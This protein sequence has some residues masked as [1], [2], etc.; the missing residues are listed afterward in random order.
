MLK[1]HADKVILR[2]HNQVNSYYINLNDVREYIKIL[3]DFLQTF[4]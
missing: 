4:K 2:Y 3:F 1:E